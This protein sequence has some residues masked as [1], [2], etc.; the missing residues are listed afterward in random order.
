MGLPGISLIK[1]VD[2]LVLD[3]AVIS[4][5]VKYQDNADRFVAS[6]LVV[7]VDTVSTF[8][9][10]G[11]KTSTFYN[12][13]DGS[14]VFSAFILTSGTWY[15]R[16]I[17]TNVSGTTISS[18][19]TL[20]LS[21]IL[22][23]NLYQ[24]ENLSK[25][26]PL[27]SNKRIL[28]QFENLSKYGPDWTKKRGLYTYEN[29]TSDPPFPSIT[30]LSTQRAAVGSVVTLEGNGFGAK[31]LIDPENPD[32]SLRGY[33][34]A[35]YLGEILVNIVSWSWQKIVFQVPDG[36]VSGGV[37]VVLLA[38]TPPGLRE[39]NLLGLE[40]YEAAASDDIGLELFIC[41]KLNPNTILC[42]L[43]GA[44]SKSFQA[45]L[46]NPGSGRFTIP[47]SDTNG[48][49]RDYLSDQNF[50]LCR[51]DGKDVFKWI[52]DSRR[53][54]YVDSSELQMI[55]VSGR[56]VL[57]LLER[58]VVYPEGMPH[59]TSL[60][61][62]FTNISGAALLRILILEAQ[63]RGCLQGV[64]LDWTNTHDSLGN[65]F[66]DSLILSF[67][68]GTPLLQVAAKLSEGM[69]LFDLEM[70]PSLRLKLYK[71]KGTDQS[72]TIV[73]RPGQ[74]ILSHINQ[75]D[76]GAMT[77]TLLVEGESG[78]LVEAAHPT[79]QVDWGRREGYLQARNIPSD[80]AKLQ[81]YGER[82]LKGAAV[83]NWSIEGSVT[84]YK[85]AFGELIKPLSTY[86][87]GDWIGWYIPPEGSDTL[88]FDS[89]VRVKGVTVEEDE[90]GLL[91]YTLEL[92]NILLEHDIK[93]KQYVER[94]S[95]FSQ[96]SVL[97][98]PV[99]ETP[100]SQGHTHRHSTLSDLESDDHMQYLN[101]ERHSDEAHT[102]L[103]VVRSIKRAGSD[104]LTG[105]ITFESGGNIQ[106]TQNAATRTLTISALTEGAVKQW[107]QFWTGNPSRT[108]TTHMVKGNYLSPESDVSVW[109]VSAIIDDTGR[110][111]RFAVY[112]L[113]ANH[114]QIGG[115]IIESPPM[116]LSGKKNYLYRF[117]S[118]VL[119]NAGKY[120]AV[121]AILQ[122][123]TTLG[124]A[125]G[126]YAKD[127]VL[128]G[129]NGSARLQSLP[130]PGIT[131]DVNIGITPFAFGIL[132][133]V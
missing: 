45:V 96:D 62:T 77:N 121:A 91:S 39:S 38:P 73:Y 56:G 12:V 97:S 84:V 60:D 105:D 5:E 72:E 9:S 98:A 25:Y 82:F 23:R 16:A 86:L 32:R 3:T 116:M 115:P 19:R 126:L 131:W 34:G 49:N 37:K 40:V 113:S 30:K 128:T 94:L 75:S 106:I 83:V 108:S 1:P 35:V 15:W 41:D 36:A 51:L 87:L 123:G 21:L 80:W 33:G 18:V 120:Y 93:M 85:D 24:V 99:T 89:R 133:E 57:S 10:I 69:G 68:T 71:S 114:I 117:S 103:S 76:S 102:F 66:T 14:S 64:V 20:T 27:F 59:P 65:P 43:S 70:T 46:S 81:D 88:G 54:T 4:T 67:H 7:E 52:M 125:G 110:E 48:G 104:G 92:N 50:V 127:T 28:Y 55:E 101:H 47:R 122:T 22:K 130:A 29:I 13:S 132:L 26:G 78:S 61:R 42:Q 8:D 79:G 118:R 53:P 17:A 31:A 44:L 119:L 124:V 107:F 74:A 111:M 6:T 11:K 112:E 95:M 90:N 109:A 63:G 100:V 2:L 129:V 58:A